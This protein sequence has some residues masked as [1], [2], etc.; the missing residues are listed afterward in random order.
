MSA[1]NINAEQAAPPAIS[2]GTHAKKFL[3]TLLFSSLGLAGVVLAT[4]VLVGSDDMFNGVA[5]ALLIIAA[6]VYIIIGL[7]ARHFWLR[8]SIWVFTAISFTL[9][10]ILTWVS[11]PE[12]RC[13]PHDNMS[14]YAGCSPAR[15][16]YDTLTEFSYAGHIILGVLG[17]LGLVSLIWN[18]VKETRW[19]VVIYFISFVTAIL[20]GILY[21]VDV[22]FS[23]SP[24]YWDNP[25]DFSFNQLPTSLLVLAVTGVAVVTLSAIFLKTRVVTAKVTAPP[26]SPNYYGVDFTSP[27]A[28]AAWY[29][30]MEEFQNQSVVPQETVAPDLTEPTE[31]NLIDYSD[32]IGYDEPFTDYD[33]P[34]YMPPSTKE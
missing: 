12:V 24:D 25:G 9:S 31:S 15:T 30:F 26:S 21:A 10:L 17:G 29:A 3:K 23:I 14:L 1:S 27:E 32:F 20:A 2:S 33:D 6:D 18:R 16:W 7:F 22:V 5:T 13:G 34:T 11:M 28:R 4:L 8:V 19:V